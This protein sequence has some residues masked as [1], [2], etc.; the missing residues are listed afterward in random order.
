MTMTKPRPW[1]TP[2]AMTKWVMTTKP[3]PWDASADV[4]TK[5][6]IDQLNAV[7]VKRAEQALAEH[8][9]HEAQ[10]GLDAFIAVAEELGDIEPLRE[11]LSKIL[12]MLARTP[13]MAQGLKYVAE[14][15]VHLPK[16]RVGQ[17]YR[18]TFRDTAVDDAV[19][20]VKR[21][22]D[23]W[24]Q[25]YPGRRNK[26]PHVSATAIAAERHKVDEDK[27]INRMGRGKLRTKS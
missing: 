26:P 23:L 11:W 2:A 9:E 21:I 16:R 4:W 14:N 17:R 5:W 3:P 19:G 10:G 1:D 27:I 20:D 15:F 25:H 13:E 12:P 8:Y 18:K 7:D 24:R 22:R 6:V